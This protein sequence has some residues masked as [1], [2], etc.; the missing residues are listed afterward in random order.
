MNGLFEITYSDNTS[1]IGNL[2]KKQWN[3]GSDK[4]IKAVIFKY[5]KTV[6]MEGYEEYDLTCE[7]IH[8]VGR[9]P[10]IKV[11]RLIG[12]K[13]DMSDVIEF[14]FA[15]GEINKF[16]CEKNTEYGNLTSSTWK[17]G[18]KNTITRCYYT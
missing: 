17:E 12:R 2:L 13:R 9:K 1:Y 6:K 15:K 11:I 5:I 10:A 14:N 16:E 7:M 3:L 18:V 8:V 4:P